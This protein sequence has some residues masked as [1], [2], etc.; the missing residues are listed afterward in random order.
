MNLCKGKLQLAKCSKTVVIILLMIVLLSQKAFTVPV[1]AYPLSMPEEHIN[2]TITHVD[3]VLWAKIDGTYPIHNKAI[4]DQLP[5]VYPTPPGTTNISIILDGVE[6]DWKNYNP[7]DLHH[8]AIGDWQMIYC[9]LPRAPESFVLKIHY[10]HPVEVINGSYMVLYDLNIIEYLSE[11]DVKSVAHFN[12]LIDANYSNLR[13]S[14]AFGPDELLKPIDFTVSDWQPA[15]IT[16]DEVSEFGK[17]VPGDL[18][19]SFSEAEPKKDYS[20]P[21]AAALLV[22]IILLSSILVIYALLRR[23]RNLVASGN[24]NGLNILP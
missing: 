4:D 20:F 14:T 11:T 8:T 7:A 2:Y 10:E 3:N 18:L 17:P 24:F 13:V 9:V 1:H 22:I 19:I 21:L 15:E 6:L 23:R 5:M 12:I 16:I